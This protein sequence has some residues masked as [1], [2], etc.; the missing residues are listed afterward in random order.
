MPVV[1]VTLI[2][3]YEPAVLQ[4]LGERLT[5]A[6]RSVIDAPLDGVT[7][8][9]EEVQPAGYMRGRAA[10]SPGAPLLDPEI[11]VREYLAAMEMRDLDA[12][13]TYL[14]PGFSMTFP[15]GRRFDELDDLVTW[16]KSRYRSVGKTN[17]R[18]ES[19]PVEDGTAVYCFGTLHGIWNDGSAFAD[20]RFIDRF[21]VRSGKIVEQLV[22]NDLGEAL[23]WST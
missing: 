6:V 7:I 9:V 16:S 4:R 20:I 23:A 14:G 17:D 22:W 18:F 15:G 21:V 11:V 19:V 1:K 5:D 3:G 2:K 12:A 8:A 10:K 13:R